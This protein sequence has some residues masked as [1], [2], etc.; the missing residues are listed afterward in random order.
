MDKQE[1]DCAKMPVHPHAP[2]FQKW[3]KDSVPKMLERDM[4][5]LD[6]WLSIKYIFLMYHFKSPI[7]EIVNVDWYGKKFEAA[8]AAGFPIDKKNRFKNDVTEALLG[9]NDGFN[10][11]IVDY[12]AWLNNTVWTELIYLQETLMKYIKEA[13][14]GG[15]GDNKSVKLVQDIYDRMGTLIKRLMLEEQD[16]DDLIRRIYHRV[17]ESRLAIKPEDYARKFLENDK[18]EADT[19]YGISYQTTPKITFVGKQ[20]PK[21][22]KDVKSKS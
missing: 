5:T 20:I 15:V 6:K 3:I 13:L 14:G 21:F 17:E 11:A 22:T 10:D 19:P 9:K 8:E 7:H 1:L 16:S 12:V 18:L 2:H 4:G